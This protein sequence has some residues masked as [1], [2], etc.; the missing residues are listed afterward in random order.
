MAAM[1]APGMV[2][3]VQAQGMGLVLVLVLAPAITSQQESS[4]SLPMASLTRAGWA[5]LGQSPL[6]SPAEEG[7]EF[8]ESV[9]SPPAEEDW[10]RF[11]LPPYAPPQVRGSNYENMCSFKALWFDRGIS[12]DFISAMSSSECIG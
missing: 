8:G 1:P 4:D 10:A 9:F 7:G 11:L 2:P 5:S 6:S 3:A 12:Q